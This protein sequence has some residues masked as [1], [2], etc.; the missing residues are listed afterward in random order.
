MSKA[1]TS[2]SDSDDFEIE[3]PALPPGVRN[4]VTPEGARTLKDEIAQL[5]S[6]RVSLRLDRVEDQ[7]QRD[8]IDKRLRAL[9]ARLQS[10]QVIDPATQPKDRVLFGSTVTLSEGKQ[11]EIWRIVGIDEMDLSRGWISWMSPLATAL[12]EKKI[13]DS[14]PFMGRTLTLLRID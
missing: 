11:T 12:L 10:M 5:D 8:K 6:V 14:V 4:Y 3:L 7:A 13:G 9:G 2:E 1:F